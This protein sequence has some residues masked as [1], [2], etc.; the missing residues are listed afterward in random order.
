MPEAIKK[1][2]FVLV[3]ERTLSETGGPARLW[4]HTG[5]GAEVLSICNDDE[6]KCFGASFYTPPTDSTGV[7]HILE[8]SVL[9]GSA[10]FPVKEPFV[11]LL[12]GSL[13]TFLNAFTF[14]DKTCY[15][16]ASANLRD[17]YNLIEVYLDA[18]FHPL[19]GRDIFAQEGW[20]IEAENSVSPWIFKGV[21]YNEMKGV[22]SSPDS[23][24]AEK[25]QQ[26]VFPDNLYCLDS[27]GNPEHIPDLT[28]EAFC[29]FHSRY[30]QPGNCLFFFWGDDPED[31]RLRLLDAEIGNAG[32]A[33]PM[34]AIPLQK[35]FAAPVFV[36]EAYAAT[37]D[38]NRALFTVNWLLDERGNIA[39]AMKMEMLEHILEGL[40]GS[41]LR[42]ALME[43][44]L[45]EDT[46]GCGLETDLRQMYYSTGLKG[47]EP[48]NCGKAEAII[49]DT[50]K[51]LAEDGIDRE[52][53]AAAVNSVEFAYRE[54]NSGRFPRGLAAMIQSLSTWLYGGDPIAPLAWEE[55]LANIKAALARGEKIFEQAIRDKFL[56]NPAVRVTLLP[57]PRLG[58]VRAEAEKNRL[59]Q[60]R[61]EAS[62]IEREHYVAETAR[63]QKAQLAPDD[64]ASL[65]KI[66]ALGLADLPRRNRTVPCE[67]EQL[68]QT[69]L[70]HDLPTNGIVYLT[71]LLPIPALPQHL[72]PYLPL[73][74]RS[75][76]EWGTAREDYSQLGM[77]IAANLGSMA[78]APLPGIRLGTRSAFC[79]L[80]ITAK[81]VTDRLDELFAITSEILLEPQKDSDIILNRVAQMTLEARARLEYGLQAAGNAAA[82]SRIRARFT[83]DGAITEQMA[84]ISQLEFLRGL[85]DE[86]AATPEKVLRAFEEL[87]A[88]LI[89]GKN[90]I[91]DCAAGPAGIARA[92][93]G[94]QKLLAS[95][96]AGTAPATGISLAAWPPMADLPHGEAFITPGQ[97]NFVG[98]GANLYDLG[99]KYNGSANV[100]LRW[101][102]MGR[103]WE[104]VRVAGG[105]YGVT[106]ALDRIGGTL[107][108]T[109]YRDPNVDRTLAAYD[110]MS[111]YLR[112]FKPT[113]AQLSQAIVGAVGDLDAYL[114]PDARA[115]LSLGWY[116][117]GQTAE[118]RQQMRDEMLATT[119]ADFAAFADVLAAAANA[120]DICVIGGEAAATAATENGWTSARLI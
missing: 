40:P 4:R 113:A 64:P 29:D 97:I 41:P 118:T 12:K 101:L 112:T 94:A 104:D 105:A 87:R 44:G 50:L 22:Y 91:V 71:L 78:A 7:A 20:H 5:C 70:A 33:G 66:P 72:V 19:L 10:R 65:A 55:P 36:E 28:Y 75:L 67:I 74:G 103:L 47:V 49:F 42:R 26:A 73:F 34:P 37:E 16:V 62:N 89:T 35:K 57:D 115:A 53:V 43:S 31:E 106:C 109:S 56:N 3:S 79:H 102:R 15:P 61:D 110:G 39:E 93:D 114:L 58:G 84:G 54:N 38:E 68:P 85:I 18:V 32:P 76:L 6:N 51:K 80:A 2:N 117:S 59:A 99:Y 83:G 45:G 107:T 120:G 100:I 82:A 116:L 17:F 27:G 14:P 30:Y 52:A 46:T 23:I 81:A 69:F 9:C 24:L 111:E 48:A 98:K 13:Q 11:E 119:A 77:R 92:R 60:I 86:L 95:L 1:Y 88:L 108:C 21:V 90:A 96:P 63:L 8:H 25:S